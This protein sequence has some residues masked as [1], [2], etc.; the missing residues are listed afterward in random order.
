MLGSGLGPG[1]SKT[2]RSHP[3]HREAGRHG[4]HELAIAI[5]GRSVADYVAERAAESAEASKPDVEADVRDTSWG[6][7]EQEHRALHAPALQIA[8]RRLAEGRPE[9]PDEMS[10][11]N[12][13]HL[14]EAG[15]VK[16]LRIGSVDR[17]PSPQHAAIEL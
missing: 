14:R 16:R 10:L 11:G 8:M 7:P 15:D 13:R 12:G 2:A 9:G 4:K 1:F 5:F 3:G 17:V 6:L